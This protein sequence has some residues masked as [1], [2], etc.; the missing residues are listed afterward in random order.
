M[1][2]DFKTRHCGFPSCA[3]L[4][5]GCS[6]K[7]HLT[8][9]TYH[10]RLGVCWSLPLN[11]MCEF[12]MH[13]SLYNLLSKTAGLCSCCNG[14]DGRE[15]FVRLQVSGQQAVQG[16]TADSLFGDRCGQ[17]K[18]RHPLSQCTGAFDAW[19]AADDAFCDAA[20]SVSACEA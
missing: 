15:G 12:T 11:P 18:V 5:W 8:E 6:A 10:A 14:Q 17:L 16:I 9:H 2:A 13:M 7:A 19:C 3:V 1:F 4:A 20:G